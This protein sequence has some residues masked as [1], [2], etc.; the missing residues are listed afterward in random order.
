MVINIVTNKGP[1][2]ARLYAEVESGSEEVYIWLIFDIADSDEKRYQF[3]T[4][5]R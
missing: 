4:K 5:G 1:D 2:I 3:R